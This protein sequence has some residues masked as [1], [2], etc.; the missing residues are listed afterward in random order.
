VYIIKREKESG[1]PTTL[2]TNKKGSDCYESFICPHCG[3]RNTSYTFLD[4]ELTEI[5]K[6]LYTTECFNC[7]KEVELRYRRMRGKNY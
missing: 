4:N 6:D 7:N 3:F 2:R 1:M 5:G